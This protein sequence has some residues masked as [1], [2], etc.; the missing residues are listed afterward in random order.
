MRFIHIAD[1]HLGSSP[2]A[3]F[4]WGK[5]RAEE[6]WDSFAAVIDA[7]NEKE[8]DLLLIAGD[9]FDRPPVW[10]D[11]DRAAKLFARLTATEVVM[12]AGASDYITEDSPLRSS[13]AATAV[14]E[15]HLLHLL[16]KR[17]DRRGDLLDDGALL[18]QTRVGRQYDSVG[19]HGHPFGLLHQIIG[20]DVNA[21]AHAA[22]GA[23]LFEAG[24]DIIRDMVPHGRLH[25]QVE[26]VTVLGSLDYTRS[27][28]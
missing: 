9:L 19:F 24:V 4:L 15:H 27:R 8:I 2:E 18:A 23:H 12:I 21:H 14:V 6:I 22:H 26:A 25:K 28:A 7:C 11:L 1:L 17:L 20:V 5:N 10:A 13:Q 3:E 16:G